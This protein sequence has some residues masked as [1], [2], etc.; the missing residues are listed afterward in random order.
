MYFWWIL[1]FCQQ[2]STIIRIENIIIVNKMDKFNVS[3]LRNTQAHSQRSSQCGERSN[4]S[5]VQILDFWTLISRIDSTPLSGPAHLRFKISN[6][7]PKVYQIWRNKSFFEMINFKTYSSVLKMCF[8]DKLA[9]LGIINAQEH[10]PTP[11][12]LWD[13]DLI[14]SGWPTKV[15]FPL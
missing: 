9:H 1:N 6:D 14:S 2:P 12:E 15:N 10:P 7:P 11:S 13:R 3:G 8:L 4:Q 5:H